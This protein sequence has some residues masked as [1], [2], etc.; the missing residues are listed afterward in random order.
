MALYISFKY[1]ESRNVVY[2]G[3][4][5]GLVEFGPVQVDAEHLPGAAQAPL[6]MPGGADNIVPADVEVLPAL[7]KPQKHPVAVIYSVRAA[8]RPPG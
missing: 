4:R 1:D 6:I 3:E 5:E 2:G 8:A 7:L